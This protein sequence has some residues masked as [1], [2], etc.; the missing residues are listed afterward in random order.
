[1]CLTCD[2]SASADAVRTLCER[3]VLL[4]TPNTYVAGYTVNVGLVA[5]MHPASILCRACLQACQYPAAMLNE[6][7]SS[8]DFV[9][10]QSQAAPRLA[11]NTGAGAILSLSLHA[12]ACACLCRRVARDR[13]QEWVT[14]VTQ[15]LPHLQWLL[16]AHCRIQEQHMG[17]CLLV[18]L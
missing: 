14:A 12:R 9:M 6:F 8:C 16:S 15:E 5:E 11:C 3:V 18:T 10:P 7:F 1:M 13:V 17:M 2:N 4:F